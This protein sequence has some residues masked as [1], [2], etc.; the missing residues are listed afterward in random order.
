MLRR[1][2]AI[3]MPLP[4]EENDSD[5]DMV[6]ILTSLLLTQLKHILDEM[7]WQKKREIIYMQTSLG[8]FKCQFCSL[9][10]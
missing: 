3:Y 10:L 9:F 7:T 8:T 4:L 6:N 1:R 5:D 2:G